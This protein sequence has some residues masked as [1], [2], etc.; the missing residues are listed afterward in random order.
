MQCN[1]KLGPLLESFKEKDL[2]AIAEMAVSHEVPLGDDIVTQGESK[3]DLF[4]IL[5]KGSVVIIRDG[6]ECGQLGDP[7]KTPLSVGFWLEIH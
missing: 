6:Q 5:E 2:E 1:P 3:A 4:Y 7:S